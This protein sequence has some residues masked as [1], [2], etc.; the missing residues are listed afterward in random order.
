MQPDMSASI[1]GIYTRRCPALWAMRTTQDGVITLEASLWVA[2]SRP[3]PQ[4]WS[5]RPQVRFPAEG[6]RKGWH[7]G[8][9]SP[10]KKWGFG[11][12][13]TQPSGQ[14]L[15]QARPSPLPKFTADLLMGYWR[16]YIV[17]FHCLIMIK[18]HGGVIRRVDPSPVPDEPIPLPEFESQAV[19]NRRS[20]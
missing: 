17:N 4:N 3:W 6:G 11:R 16:G 19:R 9:C 10:V 15:W 14:S 8:P 18:L 7:V 20:H 12:R 13:L 1:A 5:S 2:Q